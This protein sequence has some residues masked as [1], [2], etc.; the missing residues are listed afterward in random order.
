MKKFLLVCFTFVF[1]LSTAWAQERMISGKVTSTEDGSALPGVNVVLKGT[2]NGTVTDT[3][4][5]YKFNVPAAGGTLVFSFIGLETQEVAL[6]ERTVVD[7]KLGLD[8]TQLNEVVVTGYGTQ[9]RRKLTTSVSSIQGG[10]IAQLATPSFVDQMAGRAAGVQ[11]TTQT[12]VIGQTP[13]INIRGINS[14]SSGTFPL[15]VVDG[16]PIITGNQSSVTPTNPLA[17]INPADI[18]SYDVLKDGAASAI[19][20]SRAAN[21]VI[22]I[23][24]KKGL[25]SKG[26]ANV[27]FAATTGYSE[28]VKRFDLANASQFE[29][30]ANAK[31]ANAGSAPSAFS[32]PAIATSGQTDWQ[33]V[34]L[35]KGKFQSYN[36][37]L[38]GSTDATSYYFSVGYQKQ[39]GNIVAND[40]ERFTFLAN[41]DHRANKFFKFGGKISFTRGVTNGLNT[42]ANA[43]SGNIAGGI[44]LFPNVTVYDPTNATGYNLSADGQ[45]IGPGANTRAITSSWTN[46]GFV[47]ANN[48][49]QATNDR[50]QTNLYGQLDLIDGLSI[51]SQIGIDYL[52]NKDFQKQ[53][54][55]HGDGRGSNGFIFNQFRTVTTWDWVN[56]IS[57]IKDF[58][59]HG[60]D[61]VGGLEYQKTITESFNGQGSS[62][63]DRFFMDHGLIGG[64][65]QNQFSGGTY[66]P[67]A[68]A[69]TFARLNYSYKDKYLVG[70]SVRRDGT[71]DLDPANRYG[72]FWGASVGYRVSQEDFY[73][74]SGISTTINDL[75]FRASYAT[76]GNVNIGSFPYAGLYAAAKY[77]SQNGIAFAQAG[78]P[79]LIWETSK[80]TDI[81]LDVGILN[82]KITVTFDWFQNDI[83]GNVLNVP[84]AP[85][86]GIPGGTIAQNI[87]VLRN[88]GLEL[89]VSATALNRN[90]FT[91]NVSANYT[92]VN[93]E[94]I[95]TFP[96]AAGVNS[97]IGVGNYLINARVGQPLN[98]IYGYTF[99][100][101][102]P[103]NGFPLYEKGT[104]QIVQRNIVNGNYSFYDPANPLNETNVTGAPLNPAD[105]SAGGDRKILG[106]TT[107]TWFGGLTNNFTY[108]NFSLEVFLRY[109]G[110]NQV[111]NQTRQDVLLGQD[112]TNTGTELLN[113]WTPENRS[114][115][116]P[117][118]YLSNNSQVNQSGVATSRFVESGNFLRIQNIQLGYSI[119]KSLLGSGDNKIASV[120][121]F[122]QVQNAITI[123]SYKGL[124]P[125]LGAGLDN[126]TNPLSRTYTI[127][128]NIGL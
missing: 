12:G 56:T 60:I 91:W 43:L 9:E 17:D 19:Y 15:V 54:P 119:P 29:T 122:A 30:I 62:F 1:A 113:S 47:L 8:I 87:G 75:K 128:V 80:K 83:D 23:T 85:S 36:L 108:K 61:F 57:Y 10:A 95:K 79:L 41:A 25:K 13:I 31:L 90:G 37:G 35:R 72:V 24:T 66:V 103:D 39:E 22:L 45:A 84:Y 69:S 78:N 93:N 59:S 46:Q 74:N 33:D 76:I 121:V 120:R 107:P 124:D 101:V 104:G 89:T 6:G 96:N 100:G 27:T 125:E 65:Y 21:G 3:D 73:K 77:G 64:N 63:S 123:S 102:N 111:Y 71:S 82:N 98:V 28:A 105:V 20:G 5:N 53:D 70:A 94:I 58:G 127:G 49:F 55:R 67:R 11:I 44:R 109:S 92:S 126:N 50:L 42:G 99:S 16:V 68:F 112:F 32:D 18:E 52:A 2:T 116:M 7:V 51:K 48:K 38:S 97:E 117:R 14:M 86:L 34:L 4:G 110:G 88:S 81:G 40:F 118:M 115:T 114:T 106:K 26:K